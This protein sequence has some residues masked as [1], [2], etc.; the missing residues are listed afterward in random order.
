M[1]NLDRHDHDR[2]YK[3]IKRIPDDLLEEL[4][5]AIHNFKGVYLFSAYTYKNQKLKWRVIWL[6]KLAWA[7]NRR[8]DCTK[9]IQM[10]DEC[11]NQLDSG[12]FEEADSG[13][14]QH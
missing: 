3:G 5:Q 10:I 8:N 11:T 2:P 14:P 4:N 12:T 6:E 9:I 1:L 13:T 7:E